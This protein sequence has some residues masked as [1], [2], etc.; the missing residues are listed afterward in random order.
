MVFNNDFLFTKADFKK[1]VDR[2]YYSHGALSM[3][4]VKLVAI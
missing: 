1:S 2:K 3:H 4:I